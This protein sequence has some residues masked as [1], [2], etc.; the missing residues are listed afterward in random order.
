MDFANANSPIPGFSTKTVPDLH[1]FDSQK[2]VLSGDL[3]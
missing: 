1:G 2:S 3:L